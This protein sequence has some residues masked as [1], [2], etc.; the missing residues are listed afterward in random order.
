MKL[1]RSF[2][3]GVCQVL[4][5]V[6]L[7]AQLAGTSY[8]CPWLSHSGTPAQQTPAAVGEETVFADTA[9]DMTADAAGE[10]AMDCEQMA[11]QPEQNAPNLCAQDCQHGQQVSQSKPP[12]F[13][14]AFIVASYFV[15]PVP[16]TPRA[17]PLGAAS[18]DL[19]AAIS[20]PHAILHCCFRI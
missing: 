16:V 18:P 13:A 19:R 14:A 12:A 11:V 20:P 4:I 15:A 6:L 7:F 5:G 3:R 10:A 9:A 1:T 17:P 2:K 8:A